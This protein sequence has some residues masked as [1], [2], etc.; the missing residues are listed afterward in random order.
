MDGYYAPEDVIYSEKK[1]SFIVTMI[2]V[3]EYDHEKTANSKIFLLNF[4]F[5]I[6]QNYRCYE[7]QRKA[8][9]LLHMKDERN[10]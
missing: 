10:N 9:E 2:T 8:Q 3:I 6:L 7:K 4:F 5:R 1:T